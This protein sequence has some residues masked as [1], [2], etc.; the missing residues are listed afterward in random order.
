MFVVF[1]ISID[2]LNVETLQLISTNA[3]FRFVSNDAKTLAVLTKYSELLTVKDGILL[4]FFTHLVFSYS[5][6]RTPAL[7]NL[8]LPC[9]ERRFAEVAIP[10]GVLET[11]LVFTSHGCTRV[12]SVS[13]Y[14]CDPALCLCPFPSPWCHWLI[15]NYDIMQ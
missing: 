2:V 10:D 3:K 8:R 4:Q 9:Q 11:P 12:Y 1:T 13:V 6:P 7:R 5:S 15:Q 14:I